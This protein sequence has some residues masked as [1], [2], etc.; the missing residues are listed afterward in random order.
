MTGKKAVLVIEDVS[1]IREALCSV[2]ES[3]GF[4]VSGCDDGLSALA[5]AAEKDFQII[6]TDYRMPNMN[7]VDTTKILRERFPASIIIGLSSDNKSAEFLGA[8]ANAFL[9]KPFKFDE[10]TQLIKL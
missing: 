1:V 8:G 5:A 9:S 7:G 2:L 6:I 10:L 4:E 3:E